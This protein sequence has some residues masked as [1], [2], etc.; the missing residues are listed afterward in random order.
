MEITIKGFRCEIK[1]CQHEWAPHNLKKIAYPPA[2]CPKCRS[3]LW[4]RPP[5]PPKIGEK[6]EQYRGYFESYSA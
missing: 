6:T 3:S 2:H 1:E 4:N 5:Q